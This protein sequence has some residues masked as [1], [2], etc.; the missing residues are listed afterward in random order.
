MQGEGADSQEESGSH[1]SET[2]LCTLEGLAL[3]FCYEKEKHGFVLFKPL[4]FCIFL[5]FFLNSQPKLI[6]T[7]HNENSLLTNA[8]PESPEDAEL[9]RLTEFTALHSWPRFCFFF[10]VFSSFQGCTCGIWKFPG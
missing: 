6:L 4:L 3:D 9:C 10:S 5:G 7:I 1:D 8:V 2:T